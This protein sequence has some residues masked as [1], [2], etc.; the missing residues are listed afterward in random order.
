MK[1]AYPIA[2][3]QLRLEKQRE[4]EIAAKKELLLSGASSL[5][6]RKS[7]GSSNT[8][9]ILSLG[10]GRA[11]GRSKLDHYVGKLTTQLKDDEEHVRRTEAERQIRLCEV[12]HREGMEQFWKL[13]H[14]APIRS[15]VCFL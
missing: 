10:L 8:S 6:E 15:V 4:M 3:S 9:D 5:A 7:G 14:A 11:H 12:Q 13:L 1:N 2:G